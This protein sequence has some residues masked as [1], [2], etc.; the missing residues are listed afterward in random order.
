MRIS[1]ILTIALVG[2]G[3]ASASASA[4]PPPCIEA[5]QGSPTQTCG[6]S[7]PQI[8]AS[9]GDVYMVLSQF[10]QGGSKPQFE[11][12]ALYRLG[13]DGSIARVAA[14]FDGKAVRGASIASA[15]NRLAGTWWSQGE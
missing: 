6:Q 5:T 9:G 3:L 7:G 11:R 15:G 14:P 13:R 8:V 4:A 10:N 2:M 12:S 1:G